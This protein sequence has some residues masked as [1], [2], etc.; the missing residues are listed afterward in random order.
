MADFDETFD[1]VIVGSGGGSMAAALVMREAGKSVLILEKTDLVGGTTARSGGVMWIPNNPLLASDGIEDDFDKSLLYLDS[2]IGDHNDLPG[3][4]RERRRTYVEQAPQMMDFLSS[5]GIEFTRVKHWPDYYDDLPGGLAAGRGVCPTLYNANRLGPWKTRLR[6]GRMGKYP[7]THEELFK[8]TTVKQSSSARF[9]AVKVGLR[10]AWAVLTRADLVG[11]GSA[12]QGRMLEASLK[13]GVDIRTDSAVSEL[14]L[15]NGKATG[16]AADTAGQTRRICARLGV[17][18]NAGGF[19]RN[20]EMRDKYQPGTRVEWSLTGPGDTGELIQEMMRHGA[21]IAQ[22][23]EMVGLQQTI[24]P[25]FENADIK[26]GA[27]AMTASPHCIL[28]DRTG[29]RYM[30]EGGSYMAYCRGMLERNRKVPAVPGWAVFDSQCMSK[31]MIAGSLPGAPKPEKWFSSGYMKKAETVEGL[32][33]AMEVDPATLEATVERF[34]SFVAQNHDDDFNRGDRAYDRWLGDPFHKPSET[35]GAINKGPFYAVPVVPG[36]VGTY[37]GVVTD[38]EARVLREDGSVIDGLYATGIS[39]A[40]VMGRTYPGAGGS[41][42]PSFVWGYV[43]A[44]HALG[45]V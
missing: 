31:Y 18:V 27:Q 44:R 39:T 29:V 2:L 41:I 40:S 19:A 16:V 21:W 23:E 22:M 37:G 43:A 9:L 15:D 45:Q 13:A 4:T 10:K 34:N 36:D 38:T 33:V 3:A 12:L 24:P 17:L 35:L 11:A 6:R 14:L 42:G 26:P 30:N 25:G 1:F 28:V 20:Q 5:K 7:A 8:L 32:A